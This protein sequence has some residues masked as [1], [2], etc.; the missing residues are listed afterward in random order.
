MAEI[1]DLSNAGFELDLEPVAIDLSV[2]FELELEPEPVSL[3]CFEH[4]PAEIGGTN[5]P[6]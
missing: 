2:G 1:F 5:E 4:P 3:D 6:V